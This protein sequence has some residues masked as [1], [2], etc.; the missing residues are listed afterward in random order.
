MPAEEIQHDTDIAPLGI[1]VS[2]LN[3]PLKALKIHN[4]VV[5]NALEGHVSH[6]TGQMTLLRL[7]DI[8]ILG[9]DNHIHRLVFLKAGIQTLEFAAKEL[10]QIIFQH[11]AVQNITL[12]DKI[13]HESVLWLIVNIL[14]STDLLNLAVIHNHH[15][16]GHRKRLFL[17]VGNVNKADT[18]ALLDVLQLRLH[19]LT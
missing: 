4:G 2:G 9:T 3:Q 12:T 16:I 14:R 19:I 7:H 15:G 6:Q 11:H 18:Q 10:H 17:I 8:N 1:I 5:M 13:G